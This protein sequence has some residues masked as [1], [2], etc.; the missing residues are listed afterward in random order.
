[1][2]ALLNMPDLPPNERRA[3]TWAVARRGYSLYLIVVFLLIFG[4]IAAGTSVFAFRQPIK[5]VWILGVL[6]VVLA[7]QVLSRIL[8]LWL[9]RETEARFY[10]AISLVAD[11]VCISVMAALVFEDGWQPSDAGFIATLTIIAAVFSYI[12]HWVFIRGTTLVSGYIESKAIIRRCDWAMRALYFS[13]MVGVLR[14]VCTFESADSPGNSLAAN[15]AIGLL[16]L[17]VFSHFV[18]L[19][20]LALLCD[21]VRRRL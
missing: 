18:L 4:A 17:G 9:P 16:G 20:C 8:L 12:A 19:I 13:A 6:S 1:M 7:L 15:A 2:K 10:F 5:I 21:D 11:L 3:D 14:Y